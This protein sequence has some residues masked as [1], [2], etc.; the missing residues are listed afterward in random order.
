MAAP[1]ALVVD[2]EARV[3]VVGMAVVVV[4]PELVTTTTTITGAVGG[5]AITG[6]TMTAITTTRITIIRELS[7]EPRHEKT[8]LWVSDQV[9]HKPGCSAT[10]DG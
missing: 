9:Q 6:M 7:F 10:E 1:G 3:L 4:V 8:C 5:G 2:R